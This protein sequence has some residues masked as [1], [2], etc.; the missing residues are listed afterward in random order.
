MQKTIE[1]DCPPGNP[2]PGYLIAGVIKDTG[3]KE[4]DPHSTMFGNWTWVYT[5]D[6]TDEQWEHIAETLELRIHALYK[7]GLIRYGSW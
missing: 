5:D 3:L 4:K 1:L 7:R 6:V 2:R